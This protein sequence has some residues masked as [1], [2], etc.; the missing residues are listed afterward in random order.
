MFFVT[1]AA[2]H[3]AVGDVRQPKFASF[4][5]NFADFMLSHRTISGSAGER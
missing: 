4:N 2:R 3:R 5:R 1:G